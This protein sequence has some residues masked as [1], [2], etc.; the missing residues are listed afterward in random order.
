MQTSHDDLI[1]EG[2][3]Q[4]IIQLKLNIECVN[5]LN[6]QLLKQIQEKNEIIKDQD[7]EFRTNTAT[8]RSEIMEKEF[9][10]ANLK[11]Q[12]QDFYSK[13]D[14]IETICGLLECTDISEVPQKIEELKNLNTS[15]HVSVSAAEVSRKANMQNNDQNEELDQEAQ[16]AFSA[17]ISRM[18]EGFEQ[19][20]TELKTTIKQQERELEE[21][22]SIINTLEQQQQRINGEK[23]NLASEYNEVTEEL[24]A[25]KLDNFKQSQD[26]KML[27]KELENKQL[28]IEEFASKG[29]T[30]EQ[31]ETCYQE[32][33][34]QV[35][36][37][38]NEYHSRNPSSGVAVCE[39]LYNIFAQLTTDAMTPPDTTP[40]FESLDTVPKPAFDERTISG[41]CSSLSNYTT[42]FMDLFNALFDEL[43][44]KTDELES[45]CQ[46]V[47]DKVN[48]SISDLLDEINGLKEDKNYLEENDMAPI[49][50]A[51]QKRVN[52][53]QR[54]IL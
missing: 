48:E 2:Q 32:T 54:M 20:I 33:F 15:L 49:A 45:K 25:A 47:N 52:E 17:E 28:E 26:N 14:F 3:N 37:A 23:E 18:K 6:R 5:D 40:L 21:R 10:N 4:E 38:I 1:K 34:N 27:S 51:L 44:K 9:E 46:S 39:A 24:K 36:Q 50:A 41:I 29:S 43:N 11:K 8:L 42:H 30:L 16:S 53:L 22:Q 7:N 12:I 35:I 19:Q 13:N 31:R